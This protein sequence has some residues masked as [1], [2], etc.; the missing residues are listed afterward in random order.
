MPVAARPQ[1][2]DLGHRPGIEVAPGEGCPTFPQLQEVFAAAFKPTLIGLAPETLATVWVT[3]SAWA[4]AKTP[5]FGSGLPMGN[6]TPV[7]IADGEHVGMGRLARGGVDTD[8][9]TYSGHASGYAVI[10]ND[11]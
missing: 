9:P 1:E 7:A 4:R 2:L 10:D 11:P 3:A 8:P 6:I 5:A